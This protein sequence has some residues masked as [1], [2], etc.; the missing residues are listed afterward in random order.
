MLYFSHM[1]SS[2]IYWPEWKR[3]LQNSGFSDEMA[4]LLETLAPFGFLISQV[5]YLTGWIFPTGRTINS[6][7][8]ISILLEDG[9]E[10]QHFAHYL[11][12]RENDL[13]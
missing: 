5:I 10:I 2:Q 1:N 7:Q 11:L 8:H 9:K 13:S 3:N 12:E 4:V 6:L